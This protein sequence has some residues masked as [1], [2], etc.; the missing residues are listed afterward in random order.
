[1]V[2]SCLPFF[3]IV[4][5]RY[6]EPRR[7]RIS[8]RLV[9]PITRLSSGCRAK[10]EPAHPATTSASAT[11]RHAVSRDVIE[12]SA[13]VAVSPGARVLVQL[14]AQ[15]QA[16]E[17]ELERGGGAGRIARAELLQRWLQGPHLADLAHV[18]RRRHRIRDVDTEPPLERGHDSLDVPACAAPEIGRA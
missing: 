10:S 2:L 7:W 9:R 3:V 8:W 6:G 13:P 1:M 15:M 12:G 14:A 5:S 11:A 17:H 18:L 4:P 16:L